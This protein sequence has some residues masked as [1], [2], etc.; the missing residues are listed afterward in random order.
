MRMDEQHVFGMK[1]ESA[2]SKASIQI[3]KIN[4][5]SQTIEIAFHYMHPFGSLFDLKWS[6]VIFDDYSGLGILACTFMDGSCR[7]LQIPHPSLI[8]SKFLK[9][10]TGTEIHL[11][12]PSTMMWRC[13]WNSVNNLAIGC[14]NGHLAV[15][16]FSFDNV[17]GQSLLFYTRVHDSSIRSLKW[18]DDGLIIS[19]GNDGRLMV[20]SVQSPWTPLQIHRS[21]GFINSVTGGKKIMAGTA[22]TSLAFVDS[23]KP[24][25]KISTLESFSEF[26]ELSN[27]STMYHTGMCRSIA[28]SPCHPFILSVSA[29][30]TMKIFNTNKIND[31]GKSKHV[32]LLELKMEESTHILT[33]NEETKVIDTQFKADK[34]VCPP[35]I[36]TCGIHL[37]IV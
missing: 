15:F 11:H 2:Y 16:K 21:V 29:D 7:I 3:W 33:F 27:A 9:H 6:P 18:I 26:A 34:L 32:Q 23:G 10:K 13:S 12:M 25:V 14:T 19:G 20:T 36:E 31:R 17:L 22:L 28:T 35:I 37:V 5:P 24:H 30:G 1:N 8:K 4:V